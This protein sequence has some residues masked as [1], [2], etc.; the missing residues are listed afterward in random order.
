M[1]LLACSQPQCSVTRRSPSR[2]DSSPVS[3]S[4]VQGSFVCV[5]SKD[6]NDYH[7]RRKQ[8]YVRHSLQICPFSK[9]SCFA[10]QN[11]ILFCSSSGAVWCRS[12]IGERLG[13]KSAVFTNTGGMSARYG[14]VQRWSLWCSRSLVI[15]LAS[16]SFWLGKVFPILGAWSS[17]TKSNHA[18]STSRAGRFTPTWCQ[19]LCLIPRTA[20]GEL[21]FT[22]NHRGRMHLWAHDEP[23]AWKYRR[24]VRRGLRTPSG[25]FSLVSEVGRKKQT[26]ASQEHREVG[27]PIGGQCSADITTVCLSTEQSS[28]MVAFWEFGDNFQFQREPF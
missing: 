21:N 5:C 18:S 20:F 3:R 1:C 15:W 26:V 28:S 13:S 27:F 24:T 17:V 25:S 9:P 19:S 11:H 6:G 8:D 7:K 2:R 14:Q 10:L 12:W 4:S 16:T 23:G 22:R